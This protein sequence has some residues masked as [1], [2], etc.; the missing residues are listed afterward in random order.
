MPLFVF[1][2]YDAENSAEKIT[3]LRDDHV[4][5][6]AKLYQAGK[7]YSCGPMTNGQGKNAKHIGSVNIVEF[8]TLKQAEQWFSEE[9]L[10]KNGVYKQTLLQPFTNALPVLENWLR[11]KS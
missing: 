1:I 10:N 6:F 5:Y 2:G 3:K 8:D 11:D 4:E 7:V 9:P